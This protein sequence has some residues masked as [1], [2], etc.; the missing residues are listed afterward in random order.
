MKKILIA[1]FAIAAISACNKAEI[2]NAPEGEAIA[3]GNAF[4]DNATKAEDPSYGTS[5]SLTSFKVW[6]T[7]NATDDKKVAIFADDLVEGTV[8]ANSVWNCANK[9]QY[10]I[11]DAKYNFAA[12]VNGI[13][14]NLGADLLP[15][16][17]E[18]D[19]DGSKDLL[20]A[21]S[22]EYTGKTSGNDK[23]AFTF[24]HLLSKVKFNITNNSSEAKGYSFLIKNIKINGNKTSGKYIVADESWSATA[25]DYTFN[26][27]T[28]A[29]GAA[30]AE[31]DAEQLLIPGSVTV[32]FTVDIIYNNATIS[33]K[34]Y[35]SSTQT[36]DAGNAYSFNIKVSVGE[37]IQ[38][39]VAANPT[40]TDVTPGIDLN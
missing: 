8:G 4:V 22:I 32:S 25:G 3:F 34:D 23:V 37:P 13:N 35:T 30:S 5:K 24:S 29:S 11:A 28:V 19:A 10:W 38:F 21:K 2:I 20:Y 26:E 31:C 1:I 9:T 12:V 18:F 39:T 27:I 36:L 7:V 16:E 40:W 14:I 6:G 33:T 17:I 15:A